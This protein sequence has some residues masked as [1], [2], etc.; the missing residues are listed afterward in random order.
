M[1][2]V[3]IRLHIGG[4]LGAMMTETEHQT[5]EPPRPAEQWEAAGRAVRQLISQIA[6]SLEPRDTS[7]AWEDGEL[8]D[9]GDGRQAG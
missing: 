9:P 4:T 1:P 7:I 3:R 2:S 6:A 5:P 8:D